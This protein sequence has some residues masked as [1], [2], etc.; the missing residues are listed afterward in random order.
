[1]VKDILRHEIAGTTI[2]L[3]HVFHRGY[4]SVIHVNMQFH[5]LNRISHSVLLQYLYYTVESLMMPVPNKLWFWKRNPMYKRI[6]CIQ[7]R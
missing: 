4:I 1:M 3:C 7:Y 2:L 5:C 6:F